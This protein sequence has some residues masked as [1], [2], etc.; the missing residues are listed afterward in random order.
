MISLDQVQLLEHKVETVVAK[1]TDLQKE[2]DFLRSKFSELKVQ[3]DEMQKANVELSAKVSLYE[4]NQPTIESGIM[5]AL[6]RLNNIEDSVLRV[7][8]VVLKL[9]FQCQ[10]RIY[11]QFLLEKNL[12]RSLFQLSMLQVL[13]LL[14]SPHLLQIHFQT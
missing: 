10:S 13:K 14:H 2:N 8:G 6:E 7:S 9:L 1:I 5:K 11:H 4:Q 12:L 3:Y